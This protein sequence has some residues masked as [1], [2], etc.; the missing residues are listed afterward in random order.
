[1][2]VRHG[3]PPFS[4]TEEGEPSAGVHGDDDKGVN[5]AP[6]LPMHVLEHLLAELQQGAKRHKHMVAQ[7][8]YNRHW[9]R[10]ALLRG[11]SQVSTT[12]F[13][14]LHELYQLFVHTLVGGC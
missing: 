8:P 4:R 1:M 2:S 13:W 5:K 11:E 14:R 7:S 12:T 9:G 6:M 3:E 10:F